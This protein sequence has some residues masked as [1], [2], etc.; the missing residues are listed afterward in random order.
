MRPEIETLSKLG[1]FPPESGADAQ[2]IKVIQDSLLAIQPPV[3]DQEAVELAGLFGE[4][5]CFGLAWTV[6]SLIETAPGWPI[7]ACLPVGSKNPWILLLQT[8]IKN[9]RRP[10]S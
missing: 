4:D 8:R 6:L 9:S 1:V 3:T 5:S 2:K 7:E 10:G